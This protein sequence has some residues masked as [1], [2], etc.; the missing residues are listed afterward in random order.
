MRAFLAALALASTTA[1]VAAPKA[2]PTAASLANETAED[3]YIYFYPLV[4]Q[5]LTRRL[6]VIAPGGLGAPVNQF[7]QRQRFPDDKF[8]TIVR[9]NADTLYSSL[10][11]DVTNG[12]LVIDVPDSGGRYYL[13]HL[14]D[15]WSETWGATGSRTTGTGAQRLMIVA[16]GWT[17]TAP[18]GVELLRS[19][20]NMGWLLGRT[21]TNGPADYD[22]VHRFQTGMTIVAAPT[23]A[24]PPPPVALAPPFEAIE[25]MTAQAFFTRAMELAAANAPHGIDTPILQRMRLLGLVP[26]QPFDWA[27]LTPAQRNALEA[28]HPGATPRIRGALATSGWMK[29]GWRTTLAGLGSY[30]ADYVHRAGVAWFGLGANLAE[31]ASY[32]SATTD[33]SGAPLSSDARYMIHFAKDELPPARAFWSLTLYNERQLFAANAI[34]RFAIGDRDDLRFNPDGSLDLYVQRDD[35]GGAKSANWLP[36]PASGRFSLTMRLYWPEKRAIEGGWAP[37]PVI[38]R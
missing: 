37:P 34:N 35:P 36:A 11:Y 25:G 6:A 20:T 32:P 2:A 27:R 16:P 33:S 17:G 26:G 28:A 15:A 24:K 31:D 10:W 14:M 4:L 22:A 38:R 9:P 13:M 29:N 8:T 5:D 19:P 3:A 23:A 21:Q 1:A 18:A 30:G 12:P 7:S